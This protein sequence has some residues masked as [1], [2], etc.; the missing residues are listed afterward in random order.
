M[1]E[2][3]LLKVELFTETYEA[4]CRKVEL[5]ASKDIGTIRLDEIKALINELKNFHKFLW[6]LM[7]RYSF[8]SSEIYRDYTDECI[9]TLNDIYLEAELYGFKDDLKIRLQ[10][11]LEKYI[12]SCFL[13]LDNTFLP[14]L[15]KTVFLK[16]LSLGIKLID[17][18]HKSL[19]VFIDKFVAKIMDN[20]SKE[21]T[22]KVVNYLE[23]Y[24]DKH[25]SDEEKLMKEV[26]YPETSNH[27]K[28]HSKFKQ[29]VLSI[30]DQVGEKNTE[31]IEEIFLGL[32]E[33]LIKHILGSDKKFADFY[34]GK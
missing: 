19:F 1:T 23:K 33:W 28:E 20:A 21:E 32:N 3:N 18:Q 12:D 25:F 31:L 14:F 5:I 34:H 11:T 8:E 16:N 27:I 24:T 13:E 15:N 10:Q 17:A 4:L 22:L 26:N 7:T 9:K 6:N 2:E 29:T 30:K